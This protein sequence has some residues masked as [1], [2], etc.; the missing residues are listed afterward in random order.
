M[1]SSIPKGCGCFNCSKKKTTSRSPRL[2]MLSLA[3]KK[4]NKESAPYT[5]GRL[6]GGVGVAV[7]ERRGQGAW[8]LIHTNICTVQ[9]TIDGNKAQMEAG[10]LELHHQQYPA[11]EWIMAQQAMAT[12]ST[13]E[14]MRCVAIPFRL[15]H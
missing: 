5:C 10:L 3:G 14:Y 7:V 2:R 4:E 1:C 15:L 8:V 11:Y 12:D 9:C 6:A 13:Y